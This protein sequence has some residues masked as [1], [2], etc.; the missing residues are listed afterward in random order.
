MQPGPK[1]KAVWAC[2]K[3]YNAIIRCLLLC[4]ESRQSA[5]GPHSRPFLASALRL[6]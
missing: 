4:T 3:S 5:F 6:R 1:E 2:L